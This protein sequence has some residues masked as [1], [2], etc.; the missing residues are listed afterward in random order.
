MEK[1]SAEGYERLPTTE[2]D[3]KEL[4]FG[5]NIH[6]G[7]DNLEAIRFIDKLSFEQVEEAEGCGSQNGCNSALP[8]DEPTESPPPHFRSISKVTENE[9]VHSGEVSDILAYILRFIVVLRKN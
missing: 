3:L 9:F 1:V 8:V 7:V 5:G 6:R 4:D 2:C